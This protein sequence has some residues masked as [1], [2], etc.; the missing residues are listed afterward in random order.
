M[1]KQTFT[2]TVP[3]EHHEPVKQALNALDHVDDKGHKGTVTD[4]NGTMFEYE[5]LGNSDQV[6]ITILANPTGAS[7]TDIQARIAGEVAQLCG[8]GAK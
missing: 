2:I 6:R 8:G 7:L 3:H 5:Q 4:P 1:E